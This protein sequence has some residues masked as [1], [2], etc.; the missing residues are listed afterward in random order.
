MPFS[1]S[2][3]SVRIVLRVVAVKSVGLASSSA[4]IASANVSVMFVPALVVV[5]PS[6]GSNVG[7]SGPVEVASVSSKQCQ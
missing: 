2:S 4:L 7:A 5:S 6:S 3:V 1:S